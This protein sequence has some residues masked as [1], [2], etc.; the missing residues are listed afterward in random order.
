MSADERRMRAAENQRRYRAARPEHYRD[1][2]VARSRVPEERER[3]RRY[4]VTRHPERRMKKYGLTAVRFAEIFEAQG[5]CCYLC[6]EPL[7]LETKRGM[8]VDH[9]HS[10]CRGA[11]SCGD[12]VRGFACMLCNN[13]IG[14]FGDDPERMR[15]VADQLE[16]AIAK[17]AARLAAAPVQGEL[18]VNVAPLRRKEESA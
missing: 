17:V 16:A 12:C 4:E 14:A 10:C 6:G 11:A 1:Y 13:G 18:P 15:R 3:R 2:A 5:G 8:H 7:D 9:D